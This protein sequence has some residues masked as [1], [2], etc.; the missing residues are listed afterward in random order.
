MR[1]SVCVCVCFVHA[2]K[3]QTKTKEFFFLVLAD[4]ISET[5][6][7]GCLN[8][9]DDEEVISA[10]GQEWHMEC[11]RCVVVELKF[12]N[13]SGMFFFFVCFVGVPPATPL[14]PIGILK[15]TVCCFARMIIGRVM[16]NPVSSA[17]K[18][19]DC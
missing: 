6:C 3:R 17:A 11:F 16:G 2:L 18:S 12:G 7:A 9:V 14:S 1:V 15:K 5:V 8:V 10:V 4:D 13:R 19:V